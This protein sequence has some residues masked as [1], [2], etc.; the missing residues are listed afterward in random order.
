M[1][2]IFVVVVVFIL[3]LQVVKLAKI[4]ENT[5][6]CLHFPATQFSKAALKNSAQESEPKITSALWN[7]ICLNTSIYL[8]AWGK[9][10]C[11]LSAATC[12]QF[13]CISYAKAHSCQ[14]CCSRM[15]QIYNVASDYRRKWT[16]RRWGD[17]IWV[18]NVTPSSV[19]CAPPDYGRV[20]EFPLHYYHLHS[21][22][23]FWSFPCS[24]DLRVCHLAFAPVKILNAY[25]KIIAILMA[26]P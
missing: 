13:R 23:Y 14:Q 22:N 19:L 1:S 6:C 11:S 4:D 8:I 18:G 25:R 10:A 2:K 12:K 7:Q 17:P 21:L 9:K 20:D 15:G 16:S 26:S 5:L 24:L 3:L